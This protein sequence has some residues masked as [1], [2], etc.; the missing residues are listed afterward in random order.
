MVRSEIFVVF[1]AVN[2]KK[3]RGNIAPTFLISLPTQCQYIRGQK[4]KANKQLRTT[5][6][7]ALTSSCCMIYIGGQYGENKSGFKRSVL[8]FKIYRQ[9]AKTRLLFLFA[10][11][12]RRVCE[13]DL[14]T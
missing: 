7:I 2:S 10:I 9:L 8:S 13:L 14:R 6:S 5:I 4:S 3:G 1:D 12:S 11:R